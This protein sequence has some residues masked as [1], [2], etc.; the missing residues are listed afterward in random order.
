VI[1]RKEEKAARSA[2]NAYNDGLE[3]MEETNFELSH[4]M[5]EEKTERMRVLCDM[6]DVEMMDYEDSLEKQKE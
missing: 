3:D 4:N 1:K 6:D 2:Q 5:Q